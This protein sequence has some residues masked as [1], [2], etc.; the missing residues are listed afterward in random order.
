MAPSASD[1]AFPLVL[2]LLCCLEAVSPAPA[3]GRPKSCFVTRSK[4]EPLDMH[5]QVKTHTERAEDC[6]E[7]CQKT[8]DCVHFTWFA[9]H[10]CHIQDGKAN[11]VRASGNALSGPLECDSGNFCYSNGVKYD[12][13]DM[14]GH[15]RTET[16]DAQD[17]Q[18]R[19]SNSE[20]CTSFVWYP[21]GGCHIQD[22]FAQKIQAEENIVSG[23]ADC[24][25][26]TTTTSMTVTTTTRT[27]TSMTT[28]TTETT[29][30][31]ITSSTSSKTTATQTLTTS[32]TTTGT[33]STSTKT[34]STTS[35]T[36]LTTEPPD[37]CLQPSRQFVPLNMAGSKRTEAS[38]PFLCQAKCRKLQGCAHFTWWKRDGGC[39]LQDADAKELGADAD[40]LAGL[41][42]CTPFPFC[43]ENRHKF[44]P[45]MADTERS[46]ER[47]PGSCQR[48]CSATSGCSH[49]T[50]WSDGGC[51]LQGA[52]AA[53][54]AAGDDVVSGPATCEHTWAS[55]DGYLPSG[56]NVY[57]GNM[58]PDQAK[59][60]CVNMGGKGF[61]YE[62]G[63]HEV[64]IVKV[65]IKSVGEVVADSAGSGW[66]SFF[67]DG[68]R[69]PADEDADDEHS[70]FDV[71]EVKDNEQLFADEFVV[72]SKSP[73]AVVQCLAAG[74]SVAL[75]VAG[76]ALACRGRQLRSHVDAELIANEAPDEAFEE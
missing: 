64:G 56:S 29:I 13:L 17:C 24:K 48:R 33:T 20:G 51:H 25:A 9:D 31:T 18:T 55:K 70:E 49:F 35:S 54:K 46:V 58:T 30:T 62:G 12:K 60:R 34:S 23:G 32:S 63:L 75:F 2:A 76:V 73:S 41:S 19:C 43:F 16:I 10:G 36:S 69:T 28:T 14:P 42:D 15:K 22:R 40:A 26:T 72:R 44:D 38:S 8:K 7:R 53:R 39:H 37:V 4:Y 59:M 67:L 66:S 21:D 6:Q 1:I 50:W 52:G 5:G 3:P 27:T 74:V 47:S 71:E 45:D 11:R 65:F 68:P 57:V 61:T